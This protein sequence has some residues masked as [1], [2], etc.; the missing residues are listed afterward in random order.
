[1]IPLAIGILKPMGI[2]MNPM[3]AGLAMTIS[4]IT[5]MLNTL[6]LKKIKLEEDD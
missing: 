4:S 6:R 2:V 3:V 1:M 5:V